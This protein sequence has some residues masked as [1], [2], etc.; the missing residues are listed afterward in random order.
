MP[1]HGIQPAACRPEPQWRGQPWS[2]W[3]YNPPDLRDLQETNQHRSPTN[4]LTQALKELPRLPILWWGGFPLHP[5][6]MCQPQA[7]QTN[8]KAC[9]VRRTLAYQAT[10]ASPFQHHRYTRQCTR[11]LIRTYTMFCPMKNRSGTVPYA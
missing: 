5:K 8:Q 10:K 7:A 9:S 3:V 4:L 6:K 2:S 1:G 11:I